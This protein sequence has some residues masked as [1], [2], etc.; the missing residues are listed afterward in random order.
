MVPLGSPRRVLPVLGALLLFSAGCESPQ[1]AP[2]QPNDGVSS[3]QF[4]DIPVPDGLR[5][6]ERLHKSDSVVV[7]DYRYGNFVYTGS[8]PVAEVASYMRDRMPQHAWE[9][10]GEDQDAKGNTTLNFRR[11]KY[12]AD[13][14]LGRTEDKT[15]QMTVTVRTTLDDEK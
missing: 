1:S 13:C 6:R 14:T 8:V 11:G 4:E 15:T 9:L 5:L 7:G 10:I 12:T 3:T 2:S